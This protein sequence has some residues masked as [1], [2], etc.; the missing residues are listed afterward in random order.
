[1]ITC[2]GRLPKAFARTLAARGYRRLTPVQRAILKVEAP[3]ADLLVSA[4]TGSGK[5]VAFGLALARRLTGSTNADAGGPRALVVAP[6][7]ELAMQVASE[8]RWLFGGTGVRI[9]CCTGGADALWSLF[10]L[11]D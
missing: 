7:R 2:Q 4:R 8:L 9:G 11:W 3:D 10:F 6:T 1:M 5:T